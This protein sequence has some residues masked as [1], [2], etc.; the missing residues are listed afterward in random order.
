MKYGYIRVSTK[1]QQK[2]G[3]SLPEQKSAILERYADAII[4][5]EAKS[6]AKE[7]PIFEELIDKMVEGDLLI[8]TKLDR[9]SRSTIDGLQFVDKLMA[10]GVS[11]HILNFGLVENTPV[12]RLILT[13]FLAYAEF[14]RGMIIER[15][16]AG[17]KQKKKTDPNYKEGRKIIEVP[18]FPKFL[19]K[20]KKGEM[21]VVDSCSALGISRAK[22]Y[23][24]CENM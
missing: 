5:E 16:T 2:N 24:L 14:E 3:N 17:K 19:E 6:G 22:W 20:T 13:N 18:D 11:V 15:T 12:G 10:K 21:S 9:F 4:V 7:R 8:V 23:R 1:G